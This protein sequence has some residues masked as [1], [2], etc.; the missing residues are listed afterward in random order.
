M[1]KNKKRINTVL[2][3]ALVLLLGV[4]VV[5]GVSAI[6]ERKDFIQASKQSETI[7]NS[8]AKEGKLETQR[9]CQRN[10]M[11]YSKGILSCS[12]I[13]KKTTEVSSR[14]QVTKATEQSK[15]IFKGNNDIA[16]NDSEN[17][18]T[19]ANLYNNG[20][21]N[22]FVRERK[23]NDQHS[24]LEVGCS[25]PARAEWFPVREN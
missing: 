17:T 9:Y 20:T 13:F 8:I 4:S 2:I 1:K 23:L 12:V 19:I 3:A 21:L 24:E 10:D 16:L 5:Y 25:G 7:I 14:S 15:W 11:K 22:C 18:Y 6:N